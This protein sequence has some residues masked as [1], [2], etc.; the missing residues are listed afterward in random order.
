MSD[1]NVLTKEIAEQFLAG[2][3]SVDLSE[4]TAIEDEAAEALAKHEGY[5]DLGFLTSLSD[6]A[7]ESLSK[8]QGGLCLY[9]LKSLSSTHGHLALVNHLVETADPNS[10]IDLCSLDDFSDEIAEALGRYKGEL[11]LC[12]DENDS[13]RHVSETA[14][15]IIVSRPR[16]GEDS[17]ELPPWIWAKSNARALTADNPDKDTKFYCSI[18]LSGA[19]YWVENKQDEEFYFPNVKFLTD[20]VAN[21]LSNIKWNCITL[22]GIEDLSESAAES[23]GQMSSGEAEYAPFLS[24]CGLQRLTNETAKALAAF[25]GNL[26]LDG[27]RE[28]S[29]TM[30]RFLSMNEGERLSLDGLDR[31]TDDVA[32]WLSRH[33]G[34]CLCL[35]GLTELSDA[36][37]ESLSRH[38]GH[39]DIDLDELPESAAAILRKHPSFADED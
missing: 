22:D 1:E 20:E 16:D 23:L 27:V 26:I 5:L 7:A 18:D 9:G 15:K 11:I 31:L 36:A 39:L 12:T 8:H 28:L 19:E 13:C 35:N 30:A 24:L 32:D 10:Q 17:D 38:E 29:E 25:K 4:F 34:E 21:V 3:D 6:S 37:A 33:R 2:E 14:A